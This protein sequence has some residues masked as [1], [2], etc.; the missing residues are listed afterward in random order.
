[1]VGVGVFPC[2]AVL[3]VEVVSRLV[4][5]LLGDNIAEVL[6]NGKTDLALTFCFDIVR[7]HLYLYALG[8]LGWRQWLDIH[9][10]RFRQ[11]DAQQSLQ[12]LFTTP[13][14]VTA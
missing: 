8:R 12:L 9:D 4:E 6:V 14:G 11:A 2:L 13:A 7:S 10:I 5:V 3:Q 1:M